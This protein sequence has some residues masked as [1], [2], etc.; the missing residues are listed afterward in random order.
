MEEIKPIDLNESEKIVA[1]RKEKIQV[2]LKNPYNLS[3]IGVLLFAIAV[4]LYYFW[5]TKDQALWWDELAYGS[6]AKNFI[7]HMWDGTPTIVGELTIRP[8]IFSYIWSFLMLVGFNEVTNRFLLALVPSALSVY[9]VYL[10][11]KEVYDKKVGIIA[12][13]IFSVIWLNLFYSSRFLVHM[14]EMAFLFSSVYFFIKST[15]KEINL[16]QFCISMI[17][18]SL[19]TLTRFQDGMVFFIYLI[20]LILAKKLYLNKLKF[21]YASLIGLAPLLLFFIINYITFGNI[22]PA[23]FSK[24]YLSVAKT[25]DQLAPFGFYMLGYIPS[26]LSEVFFIFFI[27]GLIY[28]IVD[29]FL[30]YNLLSQNSKRRESL[31]LILIMFAFFAFFIFVLRSVEDRYFFET[32]AS[33]AIISAIGINFCAGFLKKYS[34]I[35]S[36]LFIVAILLFGIYSEIK[37]AD[38][39]IKVKKES[40]FEAKNAFEWI[41]KNT[42]ENSTI[43]GVGIDGYTMYYSNRPYLRFPEKNYSETTIVKN[44]DYLVDQAFVD[45]PQTIVDYINNNKDT[46]QPVHIE[47]IQNQPVVVVYKILN[48]NTKFSA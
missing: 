3:L 27:I 48:S 17:L 5:I 33:L 20:V 37:F 26:F 44:A 42:P 47:Y 9:F 18:L 13:A 29:L 40:F 31:L 35:I 21:W 46:L 6:L 34:K 1:K 8:L 15:K 14:L 39:L 24:N 36:I 45:R 11:G 30:G 10:I 22:F 28:L 38:P 7:T 23:L 25:G 19:A 12:A 2:W 43:I 4:R 41:G 32:L 16:K